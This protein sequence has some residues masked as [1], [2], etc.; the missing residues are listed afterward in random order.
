MN[1]LLLHFDMKARDAQMQQAW[2]CLL[3]VPWSYFSSSSYH[4]HEKRALQAR[5]MKVKTVKKLI[6]KNLAKVRM[7][8]TV[9]IF[10]WPR[11]SIAEQC[12]FQCAGFH[13]CTWLHWVPEN[14]SHCS[15]SPEDRSAAPEGSPVLESDMRADSVHGSVHCLRSVG[16]RSGATRR[17]ARRS[18]REQRSSTL[19]AVWVAFSAPT[20]WSTICINHVVRNCAI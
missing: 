4:A 20:C 18:S 17:M 7:I 3:A 10:F 8:I 13:A 11:P 19:G 5:R 9:L 1:H 15:G 6:L 2:H 12:R 16:P 14:P